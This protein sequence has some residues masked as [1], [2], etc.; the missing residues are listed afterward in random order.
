MET[1]FIQKQ[2]LDFYDNSKRVLPWRDNKNPY[3][4]WVSEIMLQQTRVAAVIP[5]FERFISTLPTVYDLANCEEDK[6]MKLWEGLGYYSRVRNLQKAAKII[7]SDFNGEIP[8]S[9][10]EI[11]SLPGIGPYT[12]A[13]VLSIAYEQK[14]SAV[15]GNVLRVFARLLEIS[16][17]IKEKST[18]TSIKQQVSNILPDDRIGDFNQALM[19]LGATICLPNGI[20][21][22]DNCPLNTICKAYKNGTHLFIPIKQKKKQR[23]IENRTVLILENEGRFAIQKRPN[24]G[25][26]ASLFEYPN[27]ENHLSIDEVKSIYGK[28]VLP[29]EKSKHIFT[30]KE[31]HMIGYH[32]H[33]NELDK[34]IWATQVE[35]KNTY[36]IPSAF[37]KY[38]EYILENKKDI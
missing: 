10:K 18:K 15:D 1:Y 29:I 36:S 21:L 20:P 6:L 34:Y 26:L 11:E 19:E 25:L 38:T 28:Q 13:A 22:C 31:W 5:Y 32:I 3:Y 23:P 7:V 4:I 37:R 14:Y 30:H 35:I 17:D 24:T 9:R 8:N 33:V 16:T 2:L 12:S 27:V